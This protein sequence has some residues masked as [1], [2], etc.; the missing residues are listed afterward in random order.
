MLGSTWADVAMQHFVQTPSLARDSKLSLAVEFE[1][2]SLTRMNA[3]PA[4]N[5]NWIFVVCHVSQ[6]A[7]SL[8]GASW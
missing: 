8:T 7:R 2:Y 6:M 3:D 5:W 1:Y 4:V